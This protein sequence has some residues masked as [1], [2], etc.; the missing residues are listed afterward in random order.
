MLLGFPLGF[1]MVIAYWAVRRKY[2][3]SE[4]LRQIHP[5]MIAAGPSTW[6]SPYNMVSLPSPP[7]SPSESA[8]ISYTDHT[9]PLNEHH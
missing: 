2:P 7:Q 3:R 6:G 5:V 9:P 1:L 4:W 8:F